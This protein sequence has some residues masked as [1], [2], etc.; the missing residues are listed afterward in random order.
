MGCSLVLVRLF[1]GKWTK[2]ATTMRVV[3]K[4]LVV[5]CLALIRG[6]MNSCSLTAFSLLLNLAG[7]VC[8][9]HCTVTMKT[10]CCPCS[11]RYPSGCSMCCPQQPTKST[12]QIYWKLYPQLFS[13][14]LVLKI[15][16]AGD[17]NE[18]QLHHFLTFWYWMAFPPFVTGTEEQPETECWLTGNKDN[19]IVCKI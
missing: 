15:Q 10:R 16:W 4:R 11:E 2:T 7:R 18:M 6:T 14:Q 12:Y 8:R 13:C 19:G 3:F 9:K 1:Y 17:K 5:L